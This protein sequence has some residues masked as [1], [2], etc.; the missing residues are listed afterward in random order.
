[1]RELLDWLNCCRKAHSNCGLQPSIGRALGLN[2]EETA[3]Q[4][5][6]SNTSLAAA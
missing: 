3:R 6:T 5:R 2:K 4:E 1:M